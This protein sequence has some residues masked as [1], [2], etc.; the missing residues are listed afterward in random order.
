MYFTRTTP[1]L[2][3]TTNK[4]AVSDTPSPTP[5]LRGFLLSRWWSPKW[6]IERVYEIFFGNFFGW[7]NQPHIGMPS[8]IWR[9]LICFNTFR[10]SIY[11]YS[12]G[13]HQ[14]SSDTFRRSFFKAISHRW[15]CEICT[16][17]KG[18]CS[19]Q[20]VHFWASLT[21]LCFLC[22]YLY[23]N[24]DFSSLKRDTVWSFDLRRNKREPEQ[25]RTNPAVW[26]PQSIHCNWL[27]FHYSVGLTQVVYNACPNIKCDFSVVLGFYLDW[28]YPALCLV[29]DT[30][31][32]T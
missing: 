15:C 1:P 9:F 32:K 2:T 13:I 29:S 21:V 25:R 18:R 20:S 4:S 23:D 26:R 24:D 14:Y 5:P 31:D 11:H 17:C 10:W 27:Q 12:H 3:D 30:N 7:A 22:F 8:L 28:T 19:D 6:N 16:L